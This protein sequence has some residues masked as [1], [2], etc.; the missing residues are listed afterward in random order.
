[1]KSIEWIKADLNFQ[2]DHYKRSKRHMNSSDPSECEKQNLYETI[3][4]IISLAE[5]L[6][7][8]E[9]GGNGSSEEFVNRVITKVGK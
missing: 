3:G 8:D 2:I 7:I 5:M 4:K 9:H 1:M 6:E